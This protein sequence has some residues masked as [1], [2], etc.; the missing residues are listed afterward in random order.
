MAG[1][2]VVE[3]LLMEPVERQEI[4]ALKLLQEN[5]KCVYVCEGGGEVGAPGG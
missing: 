2:E 5:S 3:V 4:T 1:E